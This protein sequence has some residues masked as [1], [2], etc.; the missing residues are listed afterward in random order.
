MSIA[1]ETPE[2]WERQ[3]KN[4]EDAGY[5]PDQAISYEEM[6]RFVQQNAIK[7]SL[8]TEVHLSLEMSMEQTVAPS[9]A[10]RKWILLK[11]PPGSPG[12]ITSDHPAVLM[13]SNP[14]EGDVPYPPGHGLLGTQV[15]FPISSGLAMLGAFEIEDEQMD[16]TEALVAIVNGNTMLHAARQIYAPASDFRFQMSAG[17][18]IKTGIALPSEPWFNRT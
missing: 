18:P 3:T 17:G 15:V 10:E 4:A 7:V 9:L 1:T 12:F 13:W 6:R 14:N 16:A 2:R 11:T 5:K 8:K